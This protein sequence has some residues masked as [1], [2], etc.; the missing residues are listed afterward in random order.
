MAESVLCQMLMVLL[1][2]FIRLVYPGTGQ[3]IR[4]S[5]QA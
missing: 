2:I 3:V 5:N 4:L 1:P